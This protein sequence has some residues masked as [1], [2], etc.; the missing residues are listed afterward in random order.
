M[1]ER[2]TIQ[3]VTTSLNVNCTV[4][5]FQ[6]RGFMS[7]FNLKLSYMKPIYFY[8]TFKLMIAKKTVVVILIKF[9]K[10]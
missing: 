5:I 10:N 6:E 8:S 1:H 2:F 3:T 7:H 4:T 9:C